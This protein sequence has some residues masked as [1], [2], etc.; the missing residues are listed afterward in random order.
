MVALSVA[1]VFVVLGLVLVL[2]LKA[3]AVRTI[4]HAEK[5]GETAVEMGPIPEL[6]VELGVS[7]VVHGHVLLVLGFLVVIKHHAQ[8]V[9]GED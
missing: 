5:F 3:V 2:V 6:V 7:I 1:V 9:E 4:G 8:H